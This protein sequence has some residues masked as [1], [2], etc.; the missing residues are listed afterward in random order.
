M[1]LR[2]KKDCL[3]LDLGVDKEPKD[4]FICFA[5]GDGLVDKNG[6]KSQIAQELSVEKIVDEAVKA[7]AEVISSHGCV[8]GG[9]KLEYRNDAILAFNGGDLIFGTDD[10]GKFML[11]NELAEPTE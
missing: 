2:V 4:R 7:G 10:V 6:V 1:M 8:V 5:T 3:V 11:E 9:D